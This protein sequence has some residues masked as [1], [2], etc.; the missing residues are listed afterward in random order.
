MMIILF[1]LGHEIS[2][3]FWENLIKRINMKKKKN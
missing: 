1:I 3:T 2:Q